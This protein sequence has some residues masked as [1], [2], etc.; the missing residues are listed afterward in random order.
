MGEVGDGG[1][2]GG[3]EFDSGEKETFCVGKIASA[4]F[5]DTPVDPGVDGAGVGLGGGAVEDLEF[6]N[7]AA[8]QRLSGVR[9][10][11]TRT[12]RSPA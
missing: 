9:H 11:W 1:G 3:G 5:Q 7:Q 12:R 10:W 2:V 6:W 4:A 8:V